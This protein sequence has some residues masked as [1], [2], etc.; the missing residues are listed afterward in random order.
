M[1]KRV[2]AVV[3]AVIGGALLLWLVMRQ[4]GETTSGFDFGRLSDWLRVLAVFGSIAC[5]LVIIGVLIGILFRRRPR[6]H[7]PVSIVVGVLLYALLEWRFAAPSEWSW[8]NPITSAA[9]QV[10]PIILC[11]IAPTWLGTAIVRR[12]YARREQSI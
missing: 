12:V 11:F 9:Y 7:V 5:G 8:H 2:L 3:I 1:L 4:L 10:G 6:L